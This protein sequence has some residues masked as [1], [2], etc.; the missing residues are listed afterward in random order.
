MSLDRFLASNV[1]LPTAPAIAARIL[2]AVKSDSESNQS[3][4]RVIGADPALAAKLLSVANST[5]YAQTGTVTRVEQAIALMGLDAVKNIALSFVVLHE[6]GPREGRRFDLQRFLKRAVTGAVAAELIGLRMKRQSDEHFAAALLQDVGTLVFA[7]VDPEGYNRL[8]DHHEASGEPLRDLEMGKFD[9]DHQELG[10]E[11]LRRWGLPESLYSPI[12]HHHSPE[13]APAEHRK[14]TEVLFL[15]DGLANLYHGSQGAQHFGELRTL[16]S[17]YFQYDEEAEHLIDEVA[18]RAEELLAAY[19]VTDRRIKPYSE[20]LQEANGELGRLNLSFAQLVIELRQAKANAEKLAADLRVAN[21]QLSDLASR[22]GLTGLYNHRHFQDILRREVSEA[23]R[24]GRPLSVILLDVDHFKKVNDVH[25]HPAGDEVL[26]RVAGFLNATIRSTDFV[27]R[28]GGEEFAMV[29]TE[30]R[31]KDALI[32][33]ERV[34]RGV[35]AMEIRVGTTTIRVAVSVGVCT[36]EDSGTD[37]VPRRII[38]AADKAL[39]SAKNGGRNR[40]AVAR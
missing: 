7:L 40:T 3:L 2:E 21:E 8:L 9:C 27:A 15:A 24:Y 30:T 20:L 26:K 29:L 4:A 38:D 14:T 17:G 28:Y 34:R 5:I 6:L 19:D 39:Y 16:L 31:A 37:L 22:D 23:A 18:C 33:A 36:V 1:N 10:S 11:L 35:E 12:R 13:T 32:V 25:G